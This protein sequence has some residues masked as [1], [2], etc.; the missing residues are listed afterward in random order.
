ILSII[1]LVMANKS[2]KEYKLNPENYTHQSNTNVST[3]KILNIIALVVSSI[4]TIL[5]LLY[6]LFYGAI[7]STALMEGYNLENNGDDFEYEWEN[8]SIYEYDDEYYE[9]EEDTIQIDSLKVDDLLE[10]TIESDSLNIN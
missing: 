5:Y 10:S 6:F 8:D 1:G 3:A 2:L 9:I 4:V 7:L